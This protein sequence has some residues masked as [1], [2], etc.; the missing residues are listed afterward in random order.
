MG[1][2]GADVTTLSAFV[3]V[4]IRKWAFLYW[5]LELIPIIAGF[6]FW[7]GATWKAKTEAPNNRF[8]SDLRGRF[9]PLKVTFRRV[10][11]NRLNRL[12]MHVKGQNL[13]DRYL[14]A[15]PTLRMV[16]DFPIIVG[17]GILG[18]I[19]SWVRI[20]L[21][22]YSNLVGGAILLGG[23]IF[24]AYCHRVHKQAHEQS[25]HIEGLITTGVFSKIRHPMYLSLILMYLG[26]AIAWGV[27]WMLLP[28]VLFSALNVLTAIKEEE[29]L[30]KK[31]SR[32]YEEYMRKVPWRWIPKVF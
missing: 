6:H 1:G 12:E 19:F 9:T 24:H 21:S 14:L 2:G 26:L 22:P 32:Q 10:S 27:V 4:S 23:W 25:E 5:K 20:P 28:S 29:F 18:E 15:K 11:G 13:I 30:R 7:M 17:M 31:F 3:V 16:I 8:E